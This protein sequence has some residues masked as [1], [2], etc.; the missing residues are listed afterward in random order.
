METI[1]F[2]TVI[3]INIVIGIRY[4]TLTIQKKIIPSL[5]MWVFFTIAVTGSLLCYLFEGHFSPWDNIL[6]TSDIVL[7][8]F[9]T[10]IILIFGEPSSRFNK[11]DIYCLI[12]VLFIL[13][14]WL[15]SKAHFATHL[16]LQLVQ[17]IAYFPVFQRMIK[18]KKNTESFVTWIL[19][20]TVTLVSLG[21]SKGLLAFVYA[22]RAIVCIST[23]LILM[24]FFEL[25]MNIVTNQSSGRE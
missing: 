22:G 20:L 5:A 18:N 15:L 23:L 8:S 11:F 7:C 19:F 17:T 13:V 24:I 2:Y 9:I 25:K 6:N 3:L 21:S 12:A 4:T 1:S 16:S 10:L 14:F